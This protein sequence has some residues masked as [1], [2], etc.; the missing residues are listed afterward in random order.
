[1]IDRIIRREHADPTLFGNYSRHSAIRYQ[2]F[3]SLSP[4]FTFYSHHS[5]SSELF[6]GQFDL[7][8]QNSIYLN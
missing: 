7:S 6:R 8:T 2:H 1:M 3:C 4:I 5:S